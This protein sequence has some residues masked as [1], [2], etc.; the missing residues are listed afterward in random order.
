[1]A[2][3]YMMANVTKEEVLNILFGMI[4]TA[5]LSLTY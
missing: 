5:L 1:M 4:G 3:A 2:V